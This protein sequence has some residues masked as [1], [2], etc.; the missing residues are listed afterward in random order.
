[1]RLSCHRPL[2]TCRTGAMADSLDTV[3]AYHR[4]TK[5]HFRH[6]AAGPYGLDWKNQPDPFRTFAGCPHVALPLLGDEPDV[7][8]DDL[9]Q[10]GRVSPEPVTVA[11]LAGLLELAFGLSAWKQYGSSR[12]A[13]R[14]NPSSGNLHPT[15]AYAV[16]EGCAGVGDG[17][18]HYVSADHL[19]EHRCQIAAHTP[20]LPP[21]T[22]LVGLSSIHWR[23]AW[24][25][26]ERAYRYCQH[27]AG[28][29]LAAIRYAAAVLGWRA[30][31]LDTWGDGD[32]GAV[33][34]TDRE[35]DFGSAEREHPD[36]M[37]Q[38]ITAPEDISQTPCS[39]HPVLLAARN[40]RWLGKAN[41]LSPAHSHRWPVVDE[42]ALACTKP[43]TQ[44]SS[45]DPPPWPAPLPG[46]STRGAVTLI[47][48]RRSAQAFDGVTAISAAAFFRM[49][50]MT[51]PRARTLPW[52]TIGWKPRIHLLLFVHR[53]EGLTSGLY[54]FLRNPDAEA[55]A[56]SQLHS[57]FEWA[58]VDHCPEH[59]SLWRLATGDARG[60][61][62][63]LSCHQDIA[64]D[65]AFS[66]GML[67]E[68]DTALAAG[69]W[70]YRQLFWEAG[71]IG[72]VLYLEAE[73]AGVQG[74]GIGCYFDDAVHE[75][76]AIEGEG[77]QSLY[78]FTVGR[79]LPDTRLQTLPPY[80]HLQKR[81][82]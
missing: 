49:L 75:L 2:F 1:M 31:L 28:H 17:V 10:P 72:H 18:H 6:L 32:I 19:L 40:G 33:L 82:R 12:W 16:V 67:A 29:A 38:V 65:G 78:H 53:V 57:E 43:L 51:L 71:M 46:D 21:G 11:S 63:T 80:T 70:V 41:P 74:T 64:A 27:D 60:A 48:Q 34:G 9:Y 69:P 55:T 47:K 39:P 42:V 58:A 61:A 56:R 50:D 26:G 44:D 54:L 4:R 3:L 24:K 20:A 15:E 79:G 14:C 8:F 30:R 73:A 36:L 13:L 37:V 62:R 23:E 77:L 59:F 52:D 22:F 68:F 7:G 45:W 76:L 81:G 66:L 35:E 5:H 25:Y